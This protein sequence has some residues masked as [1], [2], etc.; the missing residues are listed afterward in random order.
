MRSAG[1]LLCVLALSLSACAQISD[2]VVL[3]PGPDGRSSALS[4]TAAA[5]EVVLSEPYAMVDV[6]GSELA[7]RQTSPGMVRDAYGR[8]LA[9]QPALP[10]VDNCRRRW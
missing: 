6:A 5:G 4:I 2:R 10:V 7:R 9:M 3:L 1:G 8:L